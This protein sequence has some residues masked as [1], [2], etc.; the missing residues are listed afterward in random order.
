MYKPLNPFYAGDNLFEIQKTLPQ[1][2]EFGTKTLNYQLALDVMNGLSIW[3]ADITDCP[4]ESVLAE[5]QYI[6]ICEANSSTYAI[7][8][9]WILKA[10]VLCLYGDYE[11]SLQAAQSAEDIIDVIIGKYQVAAL[12]FYQSIA[13]VEHCRRHGLAPDSR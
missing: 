2:L 5:Q 9:Y 8:H 7:C 10:K 13:V 3:L 1:H 12:N 6:D 4:D 11:A